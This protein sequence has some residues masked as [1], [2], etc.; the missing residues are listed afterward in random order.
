MWLQ[1]FREQD[2]RARLPQGEPNRGR[3]ETKKK[4]LC[5]SDNPE[6]Y[7]QLLDSVRSAPGTDLL[8]SSLKVNYQKPEEIIRT[9]QAQDADILL[10][11][12]PRMTFSFGS[13]Y[14]SMGDIDIPV[15]VLTTN[16]ELILID[17]HLVASLRGNGANV[18]FALSQDQARELVKLVA[19]AR[20]LEDR[21]AVLYGRPFDSTSAPARNLTVA[22]VY[23]RTGVRMQ[24]RPVEEL[25]SQFKEVDPQAARSEMERW[26]REAT[27]VIKVSDD[28]ILDACRL[29]VLLRSIVEKEGFS[30]VSIDCLSITM[31]RNPVLPFPCLAF[32]RLRDEGIT[33]AC[34]ADV[35]GML[36]SMFLET[37]QP[38]AFLYVQPH[39]RGPSEFQNCRESLCR[40]SAT[41]RLKRCA[42]EVYAS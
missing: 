2:S 26:K 30:A 16:P 21:R 22:E 24:F 11:C 32:A 6:S 42:D 13:L 7:A 23:R 34:E 37:D 4:L 9:I 28:T 31:S 20:I 27:K 33:A 25:V 40:A 14:D 15:I 38:E 35:C 29:Y 5:L 41:G 12:L 8:V 1:L 17:A 3:L 10:M 36:S 18:T 39:V 19:S